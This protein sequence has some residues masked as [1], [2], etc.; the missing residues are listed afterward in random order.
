M[1]GFGG[2]LETASELGAGTVRGM[3]AGD[4][5]DRVGEVLRANLRTLAEI[6]ADTQH[7]R[8]GVAEVREGVAEGLAEVRAALDEV[9]D[10]LGP[11]AAG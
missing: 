1:I 10:R 11:S 4:G 6:R 8:E 5:S 2:V 9:R 3:H 7:L